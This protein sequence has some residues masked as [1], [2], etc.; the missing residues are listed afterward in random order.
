[1]MMIIV[2]IPLFAEWLGEELVMGMMGERDKGP[3]EW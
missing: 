2:I 1:M 3:E